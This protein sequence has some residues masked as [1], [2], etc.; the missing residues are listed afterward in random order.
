M[1]VRIVIPQQ[2]NDGF[3]WADSRIRGIKAALCDLFGGFTLSSGEGGWMKD[4]LTLIEEPVY[5]FD[6]AAAFETASKSADLRESVRKLAGTIAK[7]LKQDCVFI[8]IDNNPE[9]V[10]AR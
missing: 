7:D 9:L 6:C 8:C 1:N 3:R 2:S 5:I 4:R 10:T